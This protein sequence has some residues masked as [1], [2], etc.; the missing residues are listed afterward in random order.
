MQAVP[1]ASTDSLETFVVGNVAKP[2]TITT[3]R[4]KGYAALDAVGFEHEVYQSQPLSA[5]MPHCAY[6]R[7]HFVFGLTKRWFLR[8]HHGA[9][10]PSISRPTSTS[11]SSTRT[12]DSVI[13]ERVEGLI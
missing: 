1:D 3:D 2:T 8:T 12:S 11:T 9:S 7:I 4:W 10:A 6:P 5:V 13:P